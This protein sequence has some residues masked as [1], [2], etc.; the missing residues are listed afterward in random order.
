MVVA[1]SAALPPRFEHRGE[2]LRLLL[3]RTVPVKLICGVGQQILVFGIGD[4]QQP[5]EDHQRHLVGFG[6]VRRAGTAQGAR[7]HQSLGQARN[8]LGINPLS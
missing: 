4:K 6:Q 7:L 3:Q 1:L 8:G 5:K 2:V